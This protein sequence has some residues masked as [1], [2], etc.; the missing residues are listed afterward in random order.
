MDV[1]STDETRP[2]DA[3][4]EPGG[5]ADARSVG[6]DARYA[7]PSVDPAADPAVDPAADPTVDPAPVAPGQRPY[8]ESGFFASIRRGLFP[9]SDQRWVGGVAGGLA[10][11]IGWDPLLVR[12]LL[13]VSFFLGGLGLILYGVGWALLPERDGRI[14]LQEA[15]RGNFDVAMLGSVAVLLGGFAWGGPLGWWDDGDGWGWLGVFFWLAVL[16]VV[17]YLIVQGVQRQRDSNAARRQGTVP[18][19]PG[20]PPAGTSTGTQ[21][22]GTPA[23]GATSGTGTPAPFTPAPPV[24][25]RRTDGLVYATSAGPAPYRQPQY[26]SQPQ[27][28]PGPVH[29][30]QPA[31]TPRPPR[32]SRGPGGA[33]VGTTLGVIMLAG[34]L[35]LAAHRLNSGSYLPDGVEFMAAWLGI[36]TVVLGVAILV[37]GLRGR[38]SGVLG[39]FAIVALLFGFGYV[40]VA[41]SVDPR[42]V[43]DAVVSG[44]EIEGLVTD[45]NNPGAA[46]ITEGTITVETIREAENGFYVRWGDPT[47]DLSQ[48]NLS[49]I[50]PGE[51]VVVPIQLGAGA[52][53]VIVPEDVPVEANASV[54]AGTVQWNVDDQDRSASGVGSDD[55]FASDEVGDDGAVLSLQ[56]EA[57]AGEVV[58]SES[59]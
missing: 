9:R 15:L 52:A 29:P 2:E 22:P 35:L 18:G 8:P 49:K 28:R 31:Y 27:Y 6:P 51:P 14:H 55:Y 23:P 10:E 26:Q 44:R 47:I 11:R 36:G 17:L 4:G 13:I 1:M 24:D 32:S 38:T 57:G 16:G 54:A 45:N 37:S 5:P 25:Y 7:G 20:T 41:E 43:D 53:V 33:A 30:P 39:F 48:L 56:I 58:V 40:A 42:W 12:G 19:G 59:N 21:V 3:T 34:A 46:T 50:E